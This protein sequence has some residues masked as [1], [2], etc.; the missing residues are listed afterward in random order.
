MTPRSGRQESTVLWAARTRSE[1]PGGILTYRGFLQPGWNAQQMAP[2]EAW[3]QCGCQ[4]AFA[5]L[6]CRNND[7]QNKGLLLFMVQVAH[8]GCSPVPYPLHSRIQAEGSARKLLCLRQR[9][10][11]RAEPRKVSKASAQRLWFTHYLS[12]DHVCH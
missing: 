10:R 7:H 2:Y 3:M 6:C 5:G 1:E 12:C 4:P 9:E 8:G 11:V